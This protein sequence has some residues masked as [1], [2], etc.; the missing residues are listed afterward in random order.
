MTSSNIV[1]GS[2]IVPV[3]HDESWDPDYRWH[4][5]FKPGFCNGHGATVGNYRT[6][7]DAVY[8][9]RHPERVS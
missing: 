7:R 5:Y 1:S 9:A 2:R 4:V 6:K 3:N 8:A